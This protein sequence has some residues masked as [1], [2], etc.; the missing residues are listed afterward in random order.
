MSY[1]LLPTEVGF[2]ALGGSSPQLPSPA[3]A[4]SLSKAS[5]AFQGRVYGFGGYTGA[6]QLRDLVHESDAPYA[7][8]DSHDAVS[9]FDRIGP[10][11]KSVQT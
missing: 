3:H 7:I 9:G 11:G 6:Y 5:G 4:P 8:Q 10:R 1:D 2:T